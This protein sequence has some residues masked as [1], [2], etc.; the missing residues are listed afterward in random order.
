MVYQVGSVLTFLALQNGAEIDRDAV[1]EAEAELEGEV[2]VRSQ[3]RLC[4]VVSDLSDEGSSL[5]DGSMFTVK[6]KDLAVVKKN[7][8]VFLVRIL[9]SLSLTHSHTHSHR[10]TLSSSITYLQTFTIQ[11]GW[12][13]TEVAFTLLTQQPRVRFSV[14]PRIYLILQ[15]LIDGTY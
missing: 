9:L 7:G 2:V 12:H 15:R 3:A 1:L 11:G 5:A 14:F 6:T 13:S 4:S 8:D 10:Y